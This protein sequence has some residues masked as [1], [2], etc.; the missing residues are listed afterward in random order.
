[1]GDWRTSIKLLISFGLLET[2]NSAD[3]PES[4]SILSLTVL[5]F[6]PD[7]PNSLVF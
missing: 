3:S 7:L 6:L 1:M 5:I 4:P 2:S